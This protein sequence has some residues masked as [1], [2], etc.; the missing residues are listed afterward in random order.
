MRATRKTY[1]KNTATTQHDTGKSLQNV[2]DGGLR[3]LKHP[4]SPVLKTRVTRVD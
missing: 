3:N 2:R 1:V 4:V